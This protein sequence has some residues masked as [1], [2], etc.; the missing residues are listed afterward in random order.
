[1]TDN[2][3]VE[4]TA[5]EAAYFESNG[6]KLPP[7]TS[8]PQDDALPPVDEQDD[9]GEDKQAQP[10][11]QKT[12]PHQALHA[13][14]M[15]RQELERQLEE[16]RRKFELF[17]SRMEEINKAMQPKEQVPDE[18]QDPI[19]AIKYTKDQLANLQR[20]QQE[21]AQQR[22]EQER[23]QQAVSQI[24]N[25]Y[26]QAWEQ[27]LSSSPDAIEAYNAFTKALDGHFQLRG[28]ADPYQRTQAIMAEERAIAVRAMQQGLDPADLIIQQAGLY[29][30]QAK[31]KQ[32]AVAQVENRQRGQAAARS[33]SNAGGQTSNGGQIT[34]AR[35]A[36]MSAEEFDAYKSKL[37]PS[38]YARI[39]GGV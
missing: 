21:Q 8:E 37:T 9:G 6:E 29:G 1:M 12:V 35:L 38:Q 30:Y 36:E 24:D 3:D 20:Q 7:D 13:E 15:R 4:L 17:E 22:A 11:K 28:I 19:A 34:A 5:D 39:M 16:S 27:K 33:I 23:Q 18:L 26:R 14:R 10:E 25:A 31:P 2:T 32:D